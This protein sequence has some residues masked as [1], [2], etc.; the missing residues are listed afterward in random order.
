[1]FI[2]PIPVDVAVG[3]II[4]SDMVIMPL[5]IDM[6]AV[7]LAPDLDSP[8]VLAGPSFHAIVMSPTEAVGI[9]T[10][11][12]DM[13]MDMDVIG[14]EAEEDVVVARARG[15]ARRMKLEMEIEESIVADLSC[16]SLRKRKRE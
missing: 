11:D 12:M 9:G 4:P 2:W 14:A 13:G 8:D 15:A 1:M 16:L 6:D 7:A 10:M 5:S 3:I